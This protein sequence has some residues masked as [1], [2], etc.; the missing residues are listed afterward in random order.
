MTYYRGNKEVAERLKMSIKTLR[1]KLKKRDITLPKDCDGRIIMTEEEIQNLQ[2][3]LR[4]S[5]NA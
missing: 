1:K 4:E 5:Q 2:F 3:E